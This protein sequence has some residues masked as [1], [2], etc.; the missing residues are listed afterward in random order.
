MSNMSSNL[1]EQW[2]S[3]SDDERDP[4]L[5]RVADAILAGHLPADEVLSM[6]RSEDVQQSSTGDRRSAVDGLWLAEEIGGL[7]H[8][9]LQDMIRLAG[10]AD[11]VVRWTAIQ[12]IAHYTA[13]RRSVGAMLRIL[14]RPYTRKPPP[15]SASAVSAI[16]AGIEDPSMLVLT[17][18][19]VSALPI[20]P[21]EALRAGRGSL[22]HHPIHAAGLAM[23][24]VPSL[25][26]LEETQSPAPLILYWIAGVLRLPKGAE[27]E[28]CR[29]RV[30]RLMGHSDARVREVV[31]QASGRLAG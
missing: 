25:P 10:D 16:V 14:G 17:T 5:S 2:R 27:Q 26:P 30:S 6:L 3:V 4:W 1:N 9:L 12:A 18:T 11:E 20:V 8:P 7:A 21:A 31:T 29:K 28:R 23:L 15:P 19:V 13:D 24:L 22:M